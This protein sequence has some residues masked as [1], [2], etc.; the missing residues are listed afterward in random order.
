[1]RSW[2]WILLASALPAQ[3]QPWIDLAGPWRISHRDDP[4]HAESAFD[5]S[6][7]ATVALPGTSF[8]RPEFFWLRKTIDL[9][10]PL[11]GAKLALTLGKVV[12]N[13]ELF[14]E[15]QRLAQIGDY[16]A[17]QSRLAR[18]RTFD[19]PPLPAGR[20]TIAV[21]GRIARQPGMVGSNAW[22][23]QPDTGPYL[24]TGVE[25]APRYAGPAFVHRLRL[26]RTLDLV[27]GTALVGLGLIPLLMFLK[28]RDRWAYFWLALHAFAVGVRRL[29]IALLIGVDSTPWASYFNT[30]GAHLMVLLEFV[31]AAL[32]LP[33]TWFRLIGW[34]LVAA[35]SLRV[36]PEWPFRGLEVLAPVVLVW[37]WRQSSGTARHWIV[38]SAAVLA[39][40][41]ASVD[42]SRGTIF[43]HLPAAQFQ[44]GPYSG[45]MHSLA[46][47]F[48][49]LAMVLLLVRGLLADRAEKQR[50]AGE[51]EAARVV[52]QFLL[53][54][55]GAR[56]QAFT[57]EAVYEPAAEVGGDFH[58]SRSDP[59]GALI[60]V[61]GDV[62]G[63]GL[64][65]AMLVSVAIGILRNEKSSSPGA[66]LG[67]LNGG[68]AG[69]TGGGFVTCCCARFAA[70]G[71]VTIANAGHPSPYCDG[72]E[73]AVEAGLPLGVVAGVAYEESAVQGESFTLVSDGVVE[74]ENSR[75]ELFGFERTREISTKSAHE[76]AAAAKAWGQNDDIT[77]VTVRRRSAA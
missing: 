71:T 59:D 27:G 13:Y 40:M 56:T 24:L 2:S 14:V 3:T 61:V 7:W 12:E 48:F 49:T 68:L 32:A 44:I 16:S 37:A 72:R 47:A 66:I 58:W 75:R 45:S 8:D 36:L 60:A 39:V 35:Y 73:V 63:K 62:S 55:S 43:E 53:P 64:R 76:I 54:S 17:A 26:E 30:Q 69:H 1:M 11:A 31:V 77:V 50:L 20:V 38:G 18:P 51:L 10:P 28:E 46:A 74:A 65:A 57:L 23:N 4:R 9:P 29:Q 5:D 70:D 34:P 22:A 42:A 25:N 15:G 67:A 41:Q 19:L 52:Q 33:A 21:R 6:R